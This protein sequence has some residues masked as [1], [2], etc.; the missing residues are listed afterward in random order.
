MITNCYFH[1]F[2]SINCDLKGSS[3]EYLHHQS[4]SLSDMFQIFQTDMTKPISLFSLK[5]D[6]FIAR[7]D[8]LEL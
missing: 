1:C 8:S 7:I 4:T 3:N 5:L 6:L 2:Y